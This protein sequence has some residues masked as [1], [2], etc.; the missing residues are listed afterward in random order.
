MQSHAVMDH[1]AVERVFAR[2]H[3][4]VGKSA[5]VSDGLLV[6]FL[7]LFTAH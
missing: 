2:R 3:A 1:H 4:V 7:G 5:I 6:P